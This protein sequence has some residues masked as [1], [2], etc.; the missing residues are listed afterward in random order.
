MKQAVSNGLPVERFLAGPRGLLAPL[1]A[2]EPFQA[3]AAGRYAEPIHGP[4]LGNV[5][6]DSARVWVRTAQ[7]AA[8][9]VAWSAS[10]RLE[11]AHRSAAVR[12]RA[13]T[14]HTVVVPLEGL[15]PDT[16]G[17][18]RGGQLRSTGGIT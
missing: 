14:D 11:G 3:Y 1:L 4:M 17:H 16:T 6:A 5:T 18:R 13:E 9:H 2:H 10:E 8:V 7:E 15:E 12:T